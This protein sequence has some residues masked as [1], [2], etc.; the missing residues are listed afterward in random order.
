MCNVS[1]KSDTPFKYWA[2]LG[3]IHSNAAG[4]MQV[5]IEHGATVNTVNHWNVTPLAAASTSL[6][7]ATVQ[8]LREHGGRLCS[9]MLSSF[10]PLHAATITGTASVMQ[11]QS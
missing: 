9:K 4:V 11:A 10:Y 1:A 6:Q 7:E 5:L 2:H 8:L 3:G